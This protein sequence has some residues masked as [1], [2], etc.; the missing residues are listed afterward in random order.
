MSTYSP[1]QWMKDLNK[2]LRSVTCHQKRRPVPLTRAFQIAKQL[3][4]EAHRRKASVWWVGNGGSSALCSH[5]SQDLLNKWGVRSQTLS[6]ASLLTCMA[7]DYG[8]GQVYARP[9]KILSKPGDL[10]IAISS[11][12]KSENILAS[13]RWALENKMGLITLSGF[14]RN[15]PLWTLPANLSFHLPSSLY[16]Q[17]E[18][19][20]ETLLH[21]VIETEWLK[22]FAGPMTKSRKMEVPI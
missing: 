1:I 10:L 22:K 4:Q 6:D 8:Y 11:S 9:L 16:G 13:A 21:A 14:D 3:L 12:G 2:H 19:G 5:L 20:H 7:N 15:N 18:I 17:V